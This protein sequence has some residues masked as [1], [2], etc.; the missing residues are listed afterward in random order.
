M[1]DETERTPEEAAAYYKAEAQKAF[2]KRDRDIAAAR[3]EADAAKKAAG[4]TAE[5][6]T[7]LEELRKA[8]EAAEEERAKKAG[9]FDTLKSAYE[10]RVAEAEAKATE[11]NQ[12]FADTMVRAAFFSAPDIFGPDGATTLTPEFGFAGF[13]AHV[14]F[15]PGE[16][17]TSGGIVVKDRAGE[18]IRDEKNPA[19]PASFAA[20]MRQLLDTW[21]DKDA[22]LRGSQKA[23]SGSTGGSGDVGLPPDRAALA[24]RAIKGDP[25]AIEALKASRPKGAVT[26]GRF[27]EKQASAKAAG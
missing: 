23:G 1:A 14:E 6:R 8:R 3:A 25:E 12:R 7:E 16:N 19:E 4:V 20:G 15:V 5:E 2:E 11:A 26:R 22:I 10:K 27:W 24:D 13:R 17:G 18:I 9:E 21:P